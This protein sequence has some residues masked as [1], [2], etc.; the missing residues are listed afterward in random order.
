MNRADTCRLLFSTHG[1]SKTPTY[2]SWEAMLRR[3]YNKKQSNYNYYG[4]RGIAV[5]ERWHSFENFFSDMGKKPDALTIDRIDCNG[6]YTPNNCR[7]ATRLEQAGN[8]RKRRPKNGTEEY[9]R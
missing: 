3:C 9:R 1:M 2:R 7:W 4:G 8:R 6:N 5:C